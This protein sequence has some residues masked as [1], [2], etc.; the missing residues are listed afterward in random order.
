MKKLKVILASAILAFQP[1][2]IHRAT[3]DPRRGA[4]LE[5][6]HGNP[7]SLNNL[8]QLDRGDVPCTPGR[9]PSLQAEVNDATQERARRQY[10]C[11]GHVASPVRGL[12]PADTPRVHHQPGHRPLHQ[13]QVRPSFQERAYRATIEPAIALRAGRPDGRP[14]RSVQHAELDP[15]EIR[16][17]THHPAEGVY[18]PHHGPLG[19]PADRGIARHL[20]DGLE[21]LREE[22]GAR[23]GARRKRGGLCSRVPAPD[24]D[25]VAAFR[26]GAALRLLDLA[27]RSDAGDLGPRDDQLLSIGADPE[28]RAAPDVIV[29]RPARRRVMDPDVEQVN[30][31]GVL[32]VEP[33][34]V[35]E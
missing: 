16:R 10:H 32:R 3:I 34:Q 5:T 9:Q 4:R 21:A 17:T 8:S 13:L 28:P 35:R 1:A 29:P 30:A 20:A 24:H 11:P 18:L 22:D 7:K 23:T 31:R 2:Q 15:R 19:D 33:A 14:F 27:E 12:D 26:H 6:L 25:D